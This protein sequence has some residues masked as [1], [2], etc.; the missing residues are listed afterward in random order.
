MSQLK[1]LTIRGFKSI[2]T[3]DDFHLRKLNL[4]IGANGAGK[5]NFVDFFRL[6]R[7]LA[8]GA[9]QVFVNEQG[10]GDGFFFLGPKYTR[11]IYA[12]IEFGKNGYEFRLSPTAGSKIQ[13]TEEWA[14]GESAQS[15]KF[16]IGSGSMESN[17]KSVA[18]P[19]SNP[20]LM[21]RVPAQVFDSLSS[22]T[23]YHFHDTSML[24]PMRREHMARDNEYLR[25]DASNIGAFLTALRKASPDGYQL[26]RDTVRLIAPFFDDF[27]L[28]PEDRGGNE[29]VRLEWRQ[30]GSD[31]PFQ[32]N[33]LSDGMIRFICLTTALL[34]PNP[35]STV[36]I[37]EP[38]LGLHPF[39]LS[40]LADLI[41]SAAERT[42]V[43]VSTQSP[44]L[45]DYFEPQD[46]IVV[47]RVN[48]RSEFTRLD[49]GQLK[50]WM[51]EYSLGELWQKN[52]VRAGPTHE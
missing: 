22:V 45:V 24:A 38:E 27:R 35:P 42:Q 20:S 3:L 18:N 31:F 49:P 4:I 33:H 52:V 51:D 23:V 47:N 48:G 8:D 37:D 43:I 40:V 32:P 5:S 30:I 10:G 2:E 41:H 44:T 36:V 34:Q 39:A 28:K 14:G 7:A 19:E 13:V 17:L 1:N 11:Q 26:I 15:P 9:L 50:Q 46:V 21:K 12:R 25:P 16:S 29:M 6:L